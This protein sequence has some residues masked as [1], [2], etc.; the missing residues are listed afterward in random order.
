MK[1]MCSLRSLFLFTVNVILF[2][3]GL[4]LCAIIS[5]FVSDVSKDVHYFVSVSQLE[6]PLLFI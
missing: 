5:A 4:F 1:S 3:K 6:I 2:F